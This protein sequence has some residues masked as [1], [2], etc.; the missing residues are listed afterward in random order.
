[1][2]AANV[3]TCTAWSVSRNENDSARLTRKSTK[4]S[5]KQAADFTKHGKV[6]NLCGE[7][8]CSGAVIFLAGAQNKFI[9]RLRLSEAERNFR[10]TNRH[11]ADKLLRKRVFF[12]SS[13][14]GNPAAVVNAA[15]NRNAVSKHARRRAASF[16]PWPS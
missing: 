12:C 8:K 7:S 16:S 15:R 4:R 1:V 13:E 6:L 2:G 5:P 14:Q 10:T 9:I 11:Y 3:L